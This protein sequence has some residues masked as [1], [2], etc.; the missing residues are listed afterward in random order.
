MR[1]VTV[2]RTDNY[3]TLVDNDGKPLA[4]QIQWSVEVDGVETSNY[5]TRTRARAEARRLRA[6][7]PEEVSHV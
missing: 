6:E 3:G 5:D 1:R 7:T 2:R 4:R